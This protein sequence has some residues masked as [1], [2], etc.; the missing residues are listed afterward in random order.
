M[1]PIQRDISALGGRLAQAPGRQ[2]RSRSRQRSANPSI[3][4]GT[5]PQDRVLQ[6]IGDGAVVPEGLHGIDDP[7][8]PRDDQHHHG[9]V[10]Q[11]ERLTEP[12]ALHVVTYPLPSSRHDVIGNRHRARRGRR[13]GRLRRRADPGTL[14]MSRTKP[15]IKTA[16]GRAY[17]AA[18]HASRR[19][20]IDLASQPRVGLELQFL[21]GEVVIRLGCWKSDCRFWPIMTNVDRRIASSDT[22]SVSVGH[23]LCWM[24][25]IHTVNSTMWI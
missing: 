20:P 17:R 25:S 5:V 6:A 3:G 18:D 16:T 10:N 4:L 1:I 11:T 2:R 21:F 19:W 14:F 22:I 7:H 15:A 8:D 9:N 24:N 12:P 23:G 13:P